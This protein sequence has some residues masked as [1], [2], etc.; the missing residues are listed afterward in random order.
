MGLGQWFLT[1]VRSNPRGSVSQSQGFGGG[2]DTHTVCVS[3]PFTPLVQERLAA[4]SWASGAPLQNGNTSPPLTSTVQWGSGAPLQSGNTSPPLSTSALKKN[5]TVSYVYLCEQSFSR[6][7]DIKTKKRNRLCCENDMRVALAKVKPRISE[8]V[9]ERQQQK[10]HWFAVNIHY[11]VFVFVWNSCFVGFVLWTVILCATDA[12]FILCTNKTYT[13]V[14][15]LKKSYFIFP[16]TKGSVNARMKLA[17]FSTSNKV[18][19][20]WPRGPWRTDPL[21]TYWW[22]GQ[23]KNAAALGSL[24]AVPWETRPMSF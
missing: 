11:C 4:D 20:H 5:K 24:D 15:N 23:T 13:Y 16:I 8:L 1:W 6:M 3:V 7:V 9:S 12:W 21:C 10:S 17:G 18:K 19:N 2:Q 22:Q 14:L